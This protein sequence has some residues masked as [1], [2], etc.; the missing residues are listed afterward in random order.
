MSS[1]VM[2][3][4]QAAAVL[5]Q[6]GG[7]AP[8]VSPS[9]SDASAPPSSRRKL[10]ADAATGMRVQAVPP[11]YPQDAVKAGI[12][13]PVALTLAIDTAGAVKDVTVVSGDPALA[14][15][16]VEAVQQ[17]KYKPYLIDGAPVE[18]E[19]SVTLNFRL[20]SPPPVQPAPSGSFRNG[21]Y[22]NEYFGLYYPLSR[23]WV[24]E[25]EA[26]RKRVEASGIQGTTALLGAIRVPEKGS[27]LRA[28]SSLTLMALHRLPGG[29][30]QDCKVYLDGVA[31]SLASSK[32]GKQKGVFTEFSVSGHNFLRGDFEQRHGL[33][34]RGVVC[35][36]VKEYLLLWSVGAWL[37][38]GVE[39][40]VETLRGLQTTAPVAA[41]N[42][43]PV[44]KAKVPQGV[45][46][47]LLIRKVNPEY[48]EQAR[49]ERIQ[50]TVVLHASISKTGDVVDLEV[51]DGPIELV[52]SAVTAV[53]DWKYRPYLLAGNPIEVDTQIVVNYT[54]SH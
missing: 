42:P 19:T 23:D 36:A 24:R 50:G 2:L 3:A 15:A 52:P 25:T 40:G 48:P 53:R 7:A 44:P 35:E 45:S 4:M 18:F 33:S 34:D 5:A 1:C 46:Q 39:A 51:L 11:K 10:S 26:L 22:V 41:P 43:V 13:G 21:E 16:A 12:Q 14:P 17:W 9:P 27:L 31:S 38:D 47:G 49:R 30:T 20:K 6:D 54:L 37:K 29:A 28:D 8:P 32:E